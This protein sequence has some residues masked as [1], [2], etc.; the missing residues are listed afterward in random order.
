MF[1]DKPVTKDAKGGAIAIGNFDGVHCG[2]RR[3]L[4]QLKSLA[5]RTDGP[6]VVVTFDPPPLRILRPELSPKP[7]TTHESKCRLLREA[8]ADFVVALRT[9][10][11]L[12]QLSA[13]DF[14]DQVIVGALG[15]K[16]II[17]GPNFRFGRDRRGDVDYLHQ[18]CRTLGIEFE[19]A[20]VEMDSGDWISSTRIRKEIELG[21]IQAANRLLLQPYRIH[22]VVGTG[23]RRGRTLGFPTANLDAISVL[24]P[25]HGVYAARVSNV[26]GIEASIAKSAMH[27]P[28]ALHIGPNP[29]FGEDAKKVEAHILDFSADLYG[30]SME[31]ELLSEIRGVQKFPSIEALRAQLSKDIQTTREICLAHKSHPVQSL[32]K[33]LP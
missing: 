16:G 28:V 31:L 23:A 15:A 8:G 26:E 22:G 9:S 33:E 14:F 21:A 5:K 24:V 10:H 17:E 12:L 3:L 32:R 29:T 20:A 25:A 6:V 11:E 7:L 2:H 1:F 4:I 18:R 27:Q 30:A 13:E 19:L